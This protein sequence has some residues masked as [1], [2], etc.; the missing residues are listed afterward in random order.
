MSTVTL[1]TERLLADRVSIRVFTPDSV[2]S[3]MAVLVVRPRSYRYLPIHRLALP[4]IMASEP[5]A[6]K[7]RMEKSAPL[8]IDGWPI[9]TSPSLPIPVWRSLHRRAVAVGS[10]MW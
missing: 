6:L 10:G 3:R 1:S 5:S 2:S 7:M 4:H 9:S 8:I